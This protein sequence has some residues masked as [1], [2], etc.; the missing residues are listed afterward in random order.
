MAY[1]KDKAE[2]LA[3]GACMRLALAPWTLRQV[4]TRVDSVVRY[5]RVLHIVERRE[6][7][8]QAIPAKGSAQVAAAV[9]R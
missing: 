6:I 1:F 5:R 2:R 4:S 8:F 3:A 9:D 7:T